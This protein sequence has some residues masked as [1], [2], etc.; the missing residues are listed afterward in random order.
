MVGG[1]LLRNILCVSLSILSINLPPLHL[2]TALSAIQ[3]ENE[4][5]DPPGLHQA[6]KAH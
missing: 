1:F 4:R 2:E 6:I 5:F 3:L